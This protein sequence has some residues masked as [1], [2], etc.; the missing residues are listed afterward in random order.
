[1]P[2][3]KILG[4]QGQRLALGLVSSAAQAFLP[5]GLPRLTFGQKIGNS[6]A[7]SALATNVKLYLSNADTAALDD[8]LS[9][10]ALAWVAQF[11]CI[12]GGAAARGFP[13]ALV[14]PRN[15]AWAAA[16]VTP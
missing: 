16:G 10:F 5:A 1:M 11:I 8:K 7:T 13:A 12:N 6:I 14:A 3:Q 2:P 15:D 4:G 9:R